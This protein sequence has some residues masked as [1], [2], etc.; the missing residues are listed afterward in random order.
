MAK[1]VIFGLHNPRLRGNY[2][3]M[4]Q[5]RGY[6]VTEVTNQADM[7]RALSSG[8]FKRYV[9]D[10]NLG[11]LGAKDIS[12]ALNVWNAVR[13]RIDGI[14]VKF[15]AVSNNDETVELGANAGIPSSDTTRFDIRAFLSE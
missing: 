10:L 8:D 15:M 4:A 9:M 5:N 7:A 11:S 12:P 1:K 6:E 14:N 13:Q 2:V 3:L